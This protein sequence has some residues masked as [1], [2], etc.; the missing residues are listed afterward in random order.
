MTYPDEK[1]WTQSDNARL[2]RLH[3]QAFVPLMI[4]EFLNGQRNLVM[5]RPDLARIISAHGD[6]ILYRIPGKTAKAVNALVEA[7]ATAAFCPGG[8]QF[9]DLKFEVSPEQARQVGQSG[10]VFTPL[11][12]EA[13]ITSDSG[14]LLLDPGHPELMSYPTFEE[15]FKKINP[16]G[17]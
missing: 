7:L 8:V 14:E 6:A 2:L 9:M 4:L 16:S 3:L 11:F 12:S 5:P 10:R 17:A 1:T 13:K 15:I